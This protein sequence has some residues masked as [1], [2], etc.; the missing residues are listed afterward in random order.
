[1]KVYVLVS[2]WNDFNSLE[3]TTV[4]VDLFASIEE[5]ESCLKEK[6][7]SYIDE[8]LNP[9]SNDEKENDLREG[10]EE[11]SYCKKYW[12]YESIM[13]EYDYSLSITEKDM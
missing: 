1:M 9:D 7:L 6:A 5:A 12:H 11:R 13:N 3:D 10:F 2:L 8:F 4:S